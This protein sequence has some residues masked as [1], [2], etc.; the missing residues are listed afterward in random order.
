MHLFLWSLN[1][2][3]A[4]LQ[5]RVQ[6]EQTRLKASIQQG[7]RTFRGVG[8]VRAVPTNSSSDRAKVNAL[9]RGQVMT[10]NELTFQLPISFRTPPCLTMASAC[11]QGVGGATCRSGISFSSNPRHVVLQPSRQ[12]IE[13]FPQRH[14]L[15]A[16][17]RSGW[18]GGRNPL[19]VGFHPKVRTRLKY[20]TRAVAAEFRPCRPRI[21]GLQ[22]GRLDQLTMDILGCRKRSSSAAIPARFSNAY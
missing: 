1:P 16:I 10:L 15:C 9:K 13:S 19:E 18:S 4:R 7:F 5:V 11:T 17:L 20:V 21:K 3:G 8:N 6:H 2:S 22:Y 12:Q 14:A